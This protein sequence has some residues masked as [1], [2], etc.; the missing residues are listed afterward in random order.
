LRQR[1][2]L[3]HLNYVPRLIGWKVLE[4]YFGAQNGCFSENKNNIVAL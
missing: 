4:V 2:A 3:D 1:I